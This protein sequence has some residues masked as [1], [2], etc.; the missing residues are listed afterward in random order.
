ML[1]SAGS[2]KLEEPDNAI[3]DYED[4]TGPY[5]VSITPA[6]GSSDVSPNFTKTLDIIFSEEMDETS[7][8]TESIM[9]TDGTTPYAGSV[10][11]SNKVATFTPSG[12]FRFNKT[13]QVAIAETV[14]DIASNTSGMTHAMSFDTISVL[15][16][17][18]Q[19]PMV[20]I[21]QRLGIML[22]QKLSRVSL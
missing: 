4:T 5:V 17:T 9:V 8:T 1:F 18:G 2:C 20:N 11:Y 15:P 14:K 6:D 3:E 19:K 12:G 13:H 10:S 21:L 16:D 7:L 22:Q